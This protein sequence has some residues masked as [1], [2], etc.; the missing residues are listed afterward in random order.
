MAPV[1]RGLLL[2]TCILA[3]AA[4]DSSEERA[5]KHFQNGLE[6]LQ[7]GDAARA[8]VE[9]RNTLALDDSHKEARVT[10]ARTARASGNLPEAYANY[11]RIAEE[12]PED[13]EARQALSEI[14]ILAQ[15]WDE[16][17][18]HG[19]ALLAT[20]AE[21]DEVEVVKLAL[22]FREA[23]LAEDK[24]KIRELTRSAEDLAERNPN[25]EILVRLLIEGYLNDNRIPDA[26]AVTEAILENDSD[27]ALFYQVMAELLIAQGD[28]DRLESHFRRMLAKFPDDEET[29]GNLISLLV[30]EGRGGQ[31]EQFLRDEI[32]SAEEKLPTHVSLIALIRQLRGDDD[33]LEEIDAA[34]VAYDRPPLL[35]A[36]KAGLLFDRGERDTAISLMQSITDGVE[37]SVQTDGFKVT[38]AKMLIANG[39]EVGARQLVEEV[40][41]HDQGHV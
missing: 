4:C 28:N 29:K 34:L 6:L 1:M 14:A 18:R 22:A 37:P 13:V 33:A 10:Y 15:N 39:N 38:L 25:D 8:I 9:F 23:A 40:L 11:L 2:A 3:L 24:P 27:S 17:E 19:A 36:L 26:I 7:S 31:A 21:G 12:F 5:E 32:A 35:N 16:A 41:E 30:T 20:D